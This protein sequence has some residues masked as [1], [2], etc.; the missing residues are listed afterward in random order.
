MN[1]AVR[2]AIVCSFVLVVVLVVVVNICYIYLFII[3]HDKDAFRQF[4]DNENVATNYICLYILESHQHHKSRP[5]K[6]LLLDIET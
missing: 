1:Y 2:F 4:N 5:L 6:T 3:F